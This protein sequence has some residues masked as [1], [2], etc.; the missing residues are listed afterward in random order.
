MKTKSKTV[1]PKPQ[2]QERQQFTLAEQHEESEII[3]EPGS[4]QAQAEEA[5][6]GVK[7][8]EQPKPS[9]WTD[10]FRKGKPQ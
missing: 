7:E 4:L 5:L 3:P 10:H 8:D 1:Q 9:F 6:F 2:Q